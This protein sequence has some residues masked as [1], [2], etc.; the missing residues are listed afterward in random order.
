MFISFVAAM[1]KNRAMGI[2]GHLP[3]NVPSDMKYFMKTTLGHPIVMGSKT[4]ESMPGGKALPKRTN[5]VVTRDAHKQYEGT[6]TFTD[7]SEALKLA[8]KSPGGEE[9]MVIGGGHVFAE[10]LPIAH[11]IYLTIINAEI[12]D[13]DTFFPVLDE[14]R[15]AR[16]EVGH[17]EKNNENEYSGTF[18]IYERTGHY[19]IVEPANGRNEEYQNQLNRI[20]E[21]GICPF[22]AGGETLREQEIL[23]QNKNW[24]V[25][26]NAHPLANTLCH[27]VI[28]PHRHIESVDAI[29]PEEWLDLQE[30][31]AW[32]KAQYNFTGDA[33]Y[34]RSGEPLV[35]G[36]TVAHLHWHL[37]VPTGHVDVAFGQF[38]R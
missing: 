37:I 18:Y 15:W 29:S 31:R 24:W 10:M 8:A 35:T 3:W 6:S 9:I 36:A 28:T 26:E 38:P 7:L 13:A 2:N 22:C 16:K 1:A 4:F 5:I 20:L 17:F 12:E 30:M 21:S 19:P 27:F 32:L 25:K 34:V 33:M 14:T 11:R 23:R